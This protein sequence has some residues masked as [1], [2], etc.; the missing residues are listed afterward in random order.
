VPKIFI[1]LGASSYSLYLTHPFVVAAFAKAWA[2]GY[3]TM[4]DGFRRRQ[5]RGMLPS[6]NPSTS[7]LR[8]TP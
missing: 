4:F 6:I 1:A 7:A 8:L 3:L 2:L 5:A